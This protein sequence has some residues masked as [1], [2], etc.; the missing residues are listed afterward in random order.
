MDPEAERTKCHQ[1]TGPQEVRSGLS[2]EYVQ[3]DESIWNQNMLAKVL[4]Q[5]KDSEIA[6]LRFVDGSYKP[7]EYEKWI[8][9]INRA[10]KGF[11]PKIGSYWERVRQHA[12]D[13]YL[14]YIKDLS[15]TRVMLQPAQK[16]DR[17]PI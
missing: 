5:M 4:L 1:A 15:Y 14:N 13:T 8:M 12:E 3:T 6:K 16:L 9:S 17:T 11:R 7:F 2:P 10:M